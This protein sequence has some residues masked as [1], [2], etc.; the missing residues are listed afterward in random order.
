MLSMAQV[1]P[2]GKPLHCGR[3]KCPDN[4]KPLFTNKCLGFDTTYQYNCYICIKIELRS[5][6]RIP[7]SLSATLGYQV[8]L[9]ILSIMKTKDKKVTL[10]ANE[11]RLVLTAASIWFD[12]AEDPEDQETIEMFKRGHAILDKIREI[13]DG[14]NKTFDLIAR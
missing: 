7:G 11:L 13:T 2:L 6:P 3:T 14:D 9:K 4:P 8:T 5:N 1:T 12:T 10:Q